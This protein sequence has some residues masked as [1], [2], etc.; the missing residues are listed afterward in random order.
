MNIFNQKEHDRRKEHAQGHKLPYRVYLLINKRSKSNSDVT[1]KV[2]S[3]QKRIKC[4]INKIS[5]QGERRTV[6][7]SFQYIWG[8]TQYT[9]AKKTQAPC[10]NCS[11]HSRL[12]L[13]R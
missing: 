12:P 5:Q 8:I 4:L 2:S 3:L 9:R 6:V 7:L 10:D 1:N 13:S 11:Q